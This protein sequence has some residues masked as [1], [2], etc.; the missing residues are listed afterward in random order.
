MNRSGYEITV[1]VSQEINGGQ[2]CEDEEND[3]GEDE[4]NDNGEE[5]EG[6]PLIPTRG[7][8]CY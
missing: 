3:N 6:N 7:D 5:E 4:E 2:E 1:T 8:Y